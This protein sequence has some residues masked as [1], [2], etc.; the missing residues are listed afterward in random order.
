MPRSKR[1]R[2]V[3]LTKTP[4]RG[5]RDHKAT[6][7]KDVRDAVDNH[8]SLFLFSY[9]NMRSNKFKDIRMH[10]RPK[11]DEMDVPSRI[12]LGKNKLLQIALGKTPED[13]YSD[14]LRHVAKEI[15]ESV[16]LLFTSKPKSEVAEFFANYSEPDFARAGSVST[17]DV[18]VTNE[19]LFNH[20][21]SMVEQQFR[22]QGLPVKIEN[23]KIVL[24]DGLKEHRLCKE[25]ETLSPEK[26]KLLMHFGIKL[27]EFS[28]KLVCGWSNGEFEM[29]N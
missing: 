16:G 2:L 13:E 22:K 3:A 18:F 12:F 11:K 9:E 21:V 25:G 10:F 7:I 14:N 4:K 6:F 28:V 20:P 8:E 23:G 19:M 26:C 1:A 15:T 5:T 24:Q 17:K 27:S 29:L